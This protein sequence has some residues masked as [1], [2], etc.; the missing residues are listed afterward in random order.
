ME[1]ERERERKEWESKGG[2]RG[3]RLGRMTGNSDDALEKHGKI[4]R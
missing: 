4:P 2:Q 1:R 3:E